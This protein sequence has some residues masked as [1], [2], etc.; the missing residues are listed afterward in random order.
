MKITLPVYAVT[1]PLAFAKFLPGINLSWGGGEIT[2][3]SEI[4]T[5]GIL[6]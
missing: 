6:Q 3:E 1:S 4:Q 5:V 2:N